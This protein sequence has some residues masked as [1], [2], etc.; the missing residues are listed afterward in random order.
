[1]ENNINVKKSRK[2]LARVDECL[3]VKAKKL[4]NTGQSYVSRSK[5]KKAIPARAMRLPCEINKCKM[6]CSV[7]FKTKTE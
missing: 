7:K 6:Q 3:T 1:M 4:R 5:K 2:R